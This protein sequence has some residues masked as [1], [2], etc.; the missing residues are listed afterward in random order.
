MGS[1]LR[2]V[3]PSP[4][5]VV[6]RPRASGGE[7][8]IV[9]RT[10]R[11]RLVERLTGRLVLLEAQAGAGKSTLIDELIAAHDGPHLWVTMRTATSAAG[12]RTLFRQAAQ[13]SR[14]NE[15]ADQLEQRP[16]ATA[17][18]T[19]RTWLAE[20]SESVLV[21]LDDLQRADDDAVVALHDT[22]TSM[23]ADHRLVLAARRLDDRLRTAAH[24]DPETVTLGPA[25]L[26][27]TA[28]ETATLLG[29][30]VASRL[31]DVEVA[32]L[33]ERCDGWAAALELAGVRLRAA[34][35][36]D[37]RFGRE[38]AALLAEA[39]TLPQLLDRLLGTTSTALRH[40]IERLAALPWFDDDLAITAG[41]ADG[42]DAI[43]QLGLP[44]ES[45]ADP[46]SLDTNRD[47]GRVAFP[48]AVRDVLA[49]DQPTPDPDLAR[50]AADR[51]LRLGDP[52]SALTV[53]AAG[54]LHD[55]LAGLLA[56]IPPPL[57]G[58]LDPV[59]HAAAVA[60]LP[61]HLVDAD[62]RI[63]VHLADT[64]I[65]HGQ[66]DDYRA[67]L[68]RALA[69]LGD[70]DPNDPSLPAEVVDVVAVAFSA[71]LVAS[72]DDALVA[73]AERLLT[74]P[75][76]PEL[77]RARLLGAVGRARASTRT[78]A[79]LRQGLR[80]L[81]EAIHVF[82]RWDAVS[83]AI[84]TR[85]VAATYV[86]WPLGRY[87]VA[88]Q[89]IDRALADGRGNPR[90]RVAILPY[91]AFVLA[92]LGRSAE[93]EAVLA[94]LRRTATTIGTV[95]N[96][97]SAAFARWGAAM[98]ASQRGDAEATWAAC[99]AV[100]RSEVAVDTADG[101]FFLAD[102]AQMLAR[103]G[104][105]AD[106]RRTLARARERDPGTTPHVTVAAVT[107][108]AYAGDLSG[109]EA[110]LAELD[111][112]RAV[113]PRDRW[114]LTLLHAYAAS[115]TEDPRAAAL[116]AAAFEEAAQLGEAG[117]PLVRE[118]VA[119]RAVLD[120]AAA[121]SASARD[122]ATSR[123][124]QLRLLD[125]VEVERDGEILEPTG[126][127]AQLLAFLAVAD[128]PVSVEEAIEAL[129]PDGA[130]DRGRERL[131][132]V[133]RRTRRDIGELVE[134]HDDTLR[135]A[136]VVHSD[137]GAFLEAARTVRAGRDRGMA[138]RTALALY[139][140]DLAAN[141][142][143]AEWAESARD[144]LRRQALLM[145]DAVAEVAEHA[146]RLDDAIR[147]LRA[148]LELEPTAEDRA[149]QAAR[150]L[151]EQGRRASALQLLAQTRAQLGA[152]G[153]EPTGE[154]TRLE[155]YLAREPAVDAG[156]SSAA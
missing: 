53:L 103:V 93:A 107:V 6:V 124:V 116:A 130:A 121:A 123:G 101:A 62:P 60:S 148:A 42:V 18:D 77:A 21:V 22:I 154:L 147:V 111:G 83:H 48:D 134:R 112:G 80:E 137:V 41:V 10:A 106:A 143:Y 9:A 24:A 136:D 28:T 109:V 72:N 141:L 59:D 98:L 8:G 35:D 146:G 131:R 45:R 32:A 19:L 74:H 140:G 99:Y 153:L 81:E 50:A 91:R 89:L 118:P 30:E 58:R 125:R 47:D 4:R 67:T 86:A 2:Y 145:H 13:A 37:R 117:L 46:T 92:D 105:D 69:S 36:D 102:A 51:A 144:Q 63:L 54:R 49:G 133:L 126:R 11:P 40:A 7:A 152:V 119:T 142:G 128:R 138:A 150:L 20:Q 27:F 110:A 65:V 79:G 12:L 26:R 82:D 39:V 156:S 90:V 1:G 29:E 95:G 151:A 23:P 113:E 15:L 55:D 5:C 68:L 73:E 57:G 85:V 114:R 94:E 33:T 139:R 149:V 76:L 120:L 31:G 61:P 155:A 34:V 3:A 56:Q 78:T 38:V 84:A 14:F 52:S 75:N 97:R 104:R 88:L 96:E 127:P 87:D 71:Q 64:W 135:L 115:L 66:Q 44:L 16:A 100:D 17:L 70:V 25:E 129:W 122:I 108:A 43:A 132:T